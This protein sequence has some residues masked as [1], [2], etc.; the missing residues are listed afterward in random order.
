MQTQRLELRQ[1]VIARR[2]KSE[3]L[4]SQG[5]AIQPYLTTIVIL[6]TEV[7]LLV[8][9]TQWLWNYLPWAEKPD[10][11]SATRHVDLGQHK[12]RPQVRRLRR[13]DSR[14]VRLLEELR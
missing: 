6:L 8:I 2:A 11:V 7:I 10:L 12:C 3:A 5:V 1:E 14:S 13:E 9:K 4:V